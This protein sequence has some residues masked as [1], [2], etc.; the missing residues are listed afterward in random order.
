MLDYLA[1]TL[2]NGSP[3]GEGFPDLDQ[4]FFHFTPG[5]LP[6]VETPGELI[7]DLW[8]KIEEFPVWDEVRDL[9]APNGQ[10]GDMLSSI[11]DAVSGY[12]DVSAFAASAGSGS[13]DDTNS[14]DDADAAD[15]NDAADDMDSAT[16][17][18]PPM[19]PRSRSW[20]ASRGP[21]PSAMR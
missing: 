7:S 18:I 10:L 15:D 4:S 11:G 14:T 8:S 12:L 19:M 21:G 16:M 5:D 2:T 1:Q 6:T 9:L 13:S 20:R 17:P 3:L